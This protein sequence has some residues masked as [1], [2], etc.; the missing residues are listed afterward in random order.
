MSIAGLAIRVV[1]V[2]VR[3]LVSAMTIAG[4]AIR[5]VA[6]RLLVPA[7]TIAG[8]AIRIGGSD[9]NNS[10]KNQSDL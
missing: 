9:S 4:L 3:L 8:L 2:A 7:M 6:V 5:V 10:Q 1:A